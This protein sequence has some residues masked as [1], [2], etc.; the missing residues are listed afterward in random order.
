MDKGLDRRFVHMEIEMLKKDLGIFIY[1][2]YYNANDDMCCPICGLDFRSAYVYAEHYVA[3][4]KTFK[5]EA[6]VRR[7]ARRE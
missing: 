1:Q 7:K 2:P 3:E 6:D 4:H 5:A